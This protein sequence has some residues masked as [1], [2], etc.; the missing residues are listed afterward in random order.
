[1]HIRLNPKNTRVVYR[2]TLD[3][4]EARGLQKRQSSVDFP[5]N[6]KQYRLRHAYKM[7]TDAQSAGPPELEQPQHN[8][9]KADPRWRLRSR[10][11]GSLGLAGLLYGFFLLAAAR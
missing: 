5:E 4:N 6:L 11:R 2:G 7:N 10:A 9:A 8:H 3:T 1:M